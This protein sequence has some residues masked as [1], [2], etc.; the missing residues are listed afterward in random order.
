[1]KLRP[2][3]AAD[4]LAGPPGNAP[5]TLIYGP[6]AMRVALKRQ[7]L[8]SAIIGP[9]GEAEMRL[10]RIAAGDLRKT[11]AALADEIKATGFF[12]G[13]RVVLLDEATNQ[14]APAVAAA[15]DDWAPGDAHLVVTAGALKPAAALRKRFEA[16]RAAAALAVYAD[17]P[18]RAEVARML[19]AAGLADVPPD[20]AAELAALAQV[21]EPGD[22]AQTLEKIALYKLGDP[23]PLTSDEIALNAPASVDAGLDD[24]IDHVAEARPERIGPTLR[25]LE[26]QGLQPVALCIAASRHFRTLHAAAADPGGVARMRPPIPYARRDAVQRQSQRWG[27]RRLE[28]ALANLTD[29]DLALRSV[30]RAPQMAV[31]ERALIRLSMMPR[32]R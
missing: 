25:R 1:M 28:Q 30:A 22:F 8:V 27:V 18:D 3:D 17:P 26:G 14:H 23:A 29:T 10:S 21:M 2:R 13:P 6:D 7:A 20:A 12:P 19:G 32:G 11:P 24:L 4:W 31:M 15:L 16:D 5:G 9:D